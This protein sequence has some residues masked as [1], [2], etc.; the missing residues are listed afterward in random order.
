MTYILQIPITLWY[1][2][3]CLNSK[4]GNSVILSFHGYVVEKCALL[5]CLYVSTNRNLLSVWHEVHEGNEL[6]GGH[7]LLPVCL[8]VDMF[9]LENCLT[10]KKL[11]QILCQGGPPPDR[12]AGMS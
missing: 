7:V 12:T 10:D 2:F 11:L 6:W 1:D 3:R 5:L 4:R 8:S 9:Q